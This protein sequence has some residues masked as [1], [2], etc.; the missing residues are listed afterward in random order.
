L[1]SRHDTSISETLEEKKEEQLYMT[2]CCESSSSI[3][4]KSN[5]QS[6]GS[7]LSTSD[8]ASN[9]TTK[10]NTDLQS[11]SHDEN[12][13]RTEY[14]TQQSHHFQ[15]T[16]TCISHCMELQLHGHVRTCKTCPLNMMR[17]VSSQAIPSAFNTGTAHSTDELD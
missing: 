6:S 4:V 11:L 17:L 1:F 9:L 10:N 8:K 7:S 3:S 16:A 15:D 12:S 2:P 13:C 14:F 5:K